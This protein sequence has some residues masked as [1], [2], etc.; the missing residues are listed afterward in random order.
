MVFSD[1]NTHFSPLGVVISTPAAFR[2]RHGD[3]LPS[4]RVLRLRSVAALASSEGLGR[5]KTNSFVSFTPSVYD[6]HES[7]EINNVIFPTILQL[8]F[9][10]VVVVVLFWSCAKLGRLAI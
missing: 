5:W 9:L 7:G 8:M 2:R 10:F 1:G 3:I 4:R 6:F